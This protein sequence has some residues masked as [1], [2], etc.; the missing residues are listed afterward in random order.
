MIRAQAAQLTKAQL[1]QLIYTE[2]GQQVDPDKFTKDQLLEICDKSDLFDT[3]AASD[4]AGSSGEGGGRFDGATHVTVNL[5]V[6]DDARNYVMVSDENG[7]MSQVMKGTDV[8]LPIGIF[9]S[10]NDAVE[11]H[12]KPRTS[13]S[14]ALIMDESKRHRYPFSIVEIHKK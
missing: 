10:L 2:T 4:V 11:T 9:H 12:F 3:T 6:D 5:L 1:A 8:K 7:N 14:G 13:E